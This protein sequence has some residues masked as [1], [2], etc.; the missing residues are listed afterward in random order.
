MVTGPQP[1]AVGPERTNYCIERGLDALADALRSYGGA[2]RRITPH[3]RDGLRLP[4]TYALADIHSLS[5]A[6]M[7]GDRR[8]E[9]WFALRDALHETDHRYR[10]QLAVRYLGQDWQDAGDCARLGL[11]KACEAYRWLND[12]A[13]DVQPA[14]SL[15][16][17][18][19][20]FARATMPSEIHNLVA[21]AHGLAHSAGEL[22]GGL[23]GC[24]IMR[25]QSG[26][27]DTCK[28][29]LLHLDF[30][31]SPGWTQRLVC[32]ICDADAGECDHILGQTYMSVEQVATIATFKSV[33]P[34]MHEVTLVPRPRHPLARIA[35]R[36]VEEQKLIAALGRKP[37]EMENVL[38]HDCMY[39]CLG[40][41]T[42]PG[43]NDMP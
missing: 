31:L 16:L 15:D 3:L 35:E 10:E 30:G 7:I 4:R 40:F 8:V 41:R 27:V 20:G 11:D 13:L 28:L 32:S 24:R 38:D 26:W 22:V 9:A 43:S 14:T 6:R 17:K 25:A 29:S 39:P 34:I 36:G 21:E 12:V 1:P 23:F 42:T 2:L 33:D 19:F 18:G 37:R 5:A